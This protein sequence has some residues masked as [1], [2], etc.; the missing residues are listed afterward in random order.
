MKIREAAIA[1]TMSEQAVRTAI[2]KGKLKTTRVALNETQF[3]HEISEE[4]IKDWRENVGAHNSRADGR[5][6][7][8][9]YADATEL[10]KI[11]K[12]LLSNKLEE[13]EKLM[14]LT[15]THTK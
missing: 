6:K 13:V 10:A 8:T 5:R 11:R 2:R 4:S 9:L 15:N 7:V 14:K 3:A 12:L 1:L